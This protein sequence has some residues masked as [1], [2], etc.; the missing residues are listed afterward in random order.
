MQLFSK[1]VFKSPFFSLKPTKGGDDC[2]STALRTHF[3]FLVSNSAE[4][5]ITQSR[6]C[7]WYIRSP[8]ELPL[9]GFITFASL[10][11]CVAQRSDNEPCLVLMLQSISLSI[12]GIKGIRPL[13]FSKS[14]SHDWKTSS[15]SSSCDY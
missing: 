13:W 2:H 1:S 12:T 3:I 8:W 4:N 5:P 7:S 6:T 10:T 11:V 9:K 15:L 14:H